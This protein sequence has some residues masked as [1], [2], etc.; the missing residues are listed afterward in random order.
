MQGG[1][2]PRVFR[3]AEVHFEA[4]NWLAFCD[5]RANSQLTIWSLWMN[6]EICRALLHGDHLSFL[7]F[8]L[9]TPH[10][11]GTQQIKPANLQRLLRVFGEFLFLAYRGRAS[12]YLVRG[13]EPCTD[14]R[15]PSYTPPGKNL[16]RKLA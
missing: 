12:P 1:T 4:G 11:R 2:R 15:A 9:M 6:Q 7:P 5:G 8:L 13:F 10:H 3:D 16:C 14:H